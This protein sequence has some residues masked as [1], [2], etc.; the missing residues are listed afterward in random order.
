MT[1][2][3]MIANE[4]LQP[5]IA[6]ID[7]A[8]PVLFEKLT[9]LRGIPYFRLFS[10]DILGSCEYM[11]QELFECYS[12]TC[13]IY[14]V[15]DEEVRRLVEFL[16]SSC[17]WVNIL[18]TFSELK[19]YPVMTILCIGSQADQCCRRHGAC[20]CTRRLGSVGHAH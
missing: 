2:T 14:P 1:S 18:L 15:G 7:A 20:F 4:E 13:E 11:P 3:T 16:Y 10:V 17:C 19:Q 8:N 9:Q 6:A 12:E 5:A